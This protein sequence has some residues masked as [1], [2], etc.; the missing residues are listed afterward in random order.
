MKKRRNV[1][2]G[3]EEG[4]R[5]VRP[6]PAPLLRLEMAISSFS[7]PSSTVHLTTG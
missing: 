4:M 1:I 2:V 3:R 7:F 6:T 5:E